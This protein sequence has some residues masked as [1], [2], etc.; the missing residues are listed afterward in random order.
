LRE[1][2]GGIVVGSPSDSAKF[3]RL[4]LFSGGR[5]SNEHGKKQK[6]EKRFHIGKTHVKESYS[7]F[8]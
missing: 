5:T 3:D 8:R 4:T 1:S 7:R 2:K 6:G